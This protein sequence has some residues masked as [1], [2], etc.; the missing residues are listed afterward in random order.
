MTG[1]PRII[2]AQ[3]DRRSGDGWHAPENKFFKVFELPDDIRLGN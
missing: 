2:C 1:K 3:G